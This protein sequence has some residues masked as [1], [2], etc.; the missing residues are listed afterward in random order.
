MVNAIFGLELGSSEQGD[1]SFCSVQ[2]RKAL[3]S[4]ADT[5]LVCW[6]LHSYFPY[7]ATFTG[8]EPRGNIQRRKIPHS[9]S[10]THSGSSCVWQMTQNIF[11]LVLRSSGRAVL[12]F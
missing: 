6:K 5:R 12:T 2:S 10:F 11:S 1:A 8:D 9:T 3:D 7:N 4:L